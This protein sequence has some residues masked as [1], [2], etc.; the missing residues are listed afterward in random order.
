MVTSLTDLTSF[1]SWFSRKLIE[2]K[3]RRVDYVKNV[4]NQLLD[5]QRKDLLR[6]INNTFLLRFSH[7]IA[8]ESF[9]E[10]YFIVRENLINS[11]EIIEKWNEKII[12]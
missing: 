9:D 10:L 1:E 3:Q 6:I 8:R 2:E 4:W 11:F 5:N 7:L 12:N